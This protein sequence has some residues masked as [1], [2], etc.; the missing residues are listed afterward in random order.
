MALVPAGKWSEHY[1]AAAFIFLS[2]ILIAGFAFA[3]Y[4]PR[5]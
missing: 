3:I 2:G 5:Q 4:L 1:F